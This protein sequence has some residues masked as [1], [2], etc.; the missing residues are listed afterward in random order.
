M[1]S[2]PLESCSVI[3]WN[4]WFDPFHYEE[5]TDA[6]IAELVTRT[7]DIVCLQEV[8]PALVSKLWNNAFIRDNYV[9][10]EFNS[11]FRYGVLTM[12]KSALAPEYRRYSFPS[13]MG[14]EL[15]VGVIE[16]K[17]N[18]SSF[19]FAVG[20]IHLESLDNQIMR[21]QQLQVCR[22]V[23]GAYD[24][25]ILV[26]DFNICSYGNLDSSS[27]EYPENE[28]IVSRL[29]GFKDVWAD[30]HP[31]GTTR[32]SRELKGYTFDSDLNKNIDH[33]E[34]RRIDRIM[35]RSVQQHVTPIDI[36][37]LGIEPIAHLSPLCVW[38]SDHFGLCA[39]L[40]LASRPLIS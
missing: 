11:S 12:I 19:P 17:K 26:G 8:L 34:V 13:E 4:V 40:G 24:N 9:L 22:R 28:D 38:P 18:G 21:V 25:S 16:L 32:T 20:N 15:L 23:L 3:T 30:L 31:A 7:A 10:S 33:N 2:L 5:R 35:L 36:A 37:M 14:R 39:E 6:I 29:D 1:E 27:T